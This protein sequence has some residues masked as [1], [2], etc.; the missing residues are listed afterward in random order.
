MTLKSFLIEKQLTE[1]NS[2]YDAAKGRH[3]AW[4]I[5]N[6][7]DSTIDYTRSPR[8]FLANEAIERI[9][10]TSTGAPWLSG[11]IGRVA[12]TTN[13]EE[14]A[15]AIAEICCYGAMLE[16]EFEISP[17][18]TGNTPTPDFRYSLGGVSGT[19]E[20]AAKLED[21]NQTHIAQE[22]AQGETP[23]GVVRSSY[24]LKGGCINTTI[25][26]SYPFGAP[27]ASKS[28]DT[29]QTN[30]ISRIC[31]IKKK[32]TQFSSTGPNLLW[33]DFRSLGSWPGVLNEEQCS[34]LIRGHHKSLCSGAIWYAFYGWKGA[35]VADDLGG[36]EYA[37]TKMAH[38]G[39]FS[40][41]PR[42][43]SLYSAAI[44]CL[45][46]ATILFE[47][48]KALMPLTDTHRKALTFLPYFRIDLSVAD[49]DKGDIQRSHTL[50]ISMMDVLL[51]AEQ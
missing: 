12:Q 8:D 42:E 25:R 40:L 17:I 33:I 13:F 16:A 50:A 39:R 51:D 28:G 21:N 27:D 18:P 43:V 5:L 37:L 26:E 32:E 30:A 49:W 24:I 14:A 7:N 2:Y 6:A 31:A 46:E 15:A 34:P 44:I 38:E 9:G 3:P 36:G 47:N 1:I 29:T 41:H 11:N 20:V 35:L 4:S 48:P 45:E 19:I 22:I 10:Q 23:E